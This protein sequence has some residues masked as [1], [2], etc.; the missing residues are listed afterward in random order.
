MSLL[1]DIFLSSGPLAEQIANFTPR[2][3]Q[4]EM[5]Q[6]ISS[7]IES[8]RCLIAE[9]GTGTG[10]TFAY[11]VPAL[12]S[13]K[14]V[15][16]SSG[17]KNLQDQL[18]YRDIPTVAKALAIPVKIA[19]LKGRANYLCH[20]RLQQAENDG[21]LSAEDA[22]KVIQVREWMGVSKN[23]DTTACEA[24]DEKDPLWSKL[25]STAD[26]CLGAECPDVTACYV[27]KARRAAQ[28]ADVVVVNH[29]LFLADLAL[30]DDGF[31][32]VLPATNTVIFDEAHQLP[33]VASRFFGINLTSRQ[34]NDLAKDAVNEIM[35]AAPDQAEIVDLGRKLDKCI[36]DTRLIMGE[37]GQRAAWANIPKQAKVVQ[38]IEKLK[39]ALE[40][41][42]DYLKDNAERAIGIERCQ[43]RANDLVSRL[44][45]FSADANASIFEESDATNKQ[46]TSNILWY[47]T[48][49]KG[50]SFHRTPVSVAEIFSEHLNGRPRCWIFTSATLTVAKR[51]NHFSEEMGI[52]DAQE[53]RWDSPFD[54]KTQ[55]LLYLPKN[56]PEPNTPRYSSAVIDAALP[57]LKASKG[58]AFFLVTSYRALNIIAERLGNELA[59]PLV[60]QGSKP[61]TELLNEFR[62]LGNAVLIGTSSFWEG[63][64]IRGDALS[65]L[66]IDKLPFAPPDDPVLQA[67]FEALR[68]QGL[69]PF[70]HYQLPGAVIALKQGVG[71]LIRGVHDRGVVML[72]DPRLL[73][74]SYGRIFL[75][76]LPDMPQSQKLGDVEKFYRNTRKINVEEVTAV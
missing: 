66:I 29:H 7:A 74:K 17:T 11:L 22:D 1:T 27:M 73:S 44:N 21:R 49:R 33:E 65:C 75:N 55:A 5:A 2:V 18:Y 32:E 24:V 69:N 76:S 31:G 6:A 47:E 46:N 13:G 8:N 37:S 67:R 34:L 28:E 14:K 19:L 35:K 72:C 60:I 68:K 71:R 50:F 40:N 42:A 9:A 20:Y 12:L 25:T 16:I 64:D 63:V 36:G 48:Q 4:I 59:Y 39:L 54:F 45:L 41:V 56:M 26:N 61:K 51:F 52:Q 3:E 57:V 70:M 53:L 10:K 62:E 30:R 43:Q 38:K 15:I 23:G 58:R